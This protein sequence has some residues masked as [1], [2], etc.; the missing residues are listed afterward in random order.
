MATSLVAAVP[1]AFL[2]FLMVSTFLGNADKMSGILMGLA[3][4]TLLV[5]GLVAAM[6]I[7]ILLFIPKE[8]SAVGAQVAERKPAADAGELES[9]EIEIDDGELDEADE[10]VEIHTGGAAAESL[11]TFEGALTDDNIPSYEGS[12]TEDTL[13]AFS[14]DDEE[15]FEAEESFEFDVE[16]DDEEK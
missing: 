10:D 13:E 16:E 5:S 2:A 6:P 4:V 11:E 15:I 7:G 14:E 9:G 3:G 1:A 8:A 12:L